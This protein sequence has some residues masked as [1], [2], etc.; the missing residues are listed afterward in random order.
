MSY[1]PTLPHDHTKIIAADLRSQFAGLKTLI[2]A[3]P[4]GQVGPQGPA[5]INGIDG[6]PGPQGPAGADGRAV[7]GVSDDG[8]GRG[9]VQMSDGTTYGP[10]TIASG[11]QGMTGNQGDP[12]PQGVPGN[13]GSDGAPGPQGPQ[14]ND[15]VS[16]SNVYDDGT[17]RAVIQLS[18]GSSFGPFT[19]ASGPQGMTGNDGPQGP[20]GPVGEISSMDL[21]TA[22]GSTSA[23]TNGVDLIAYSPSD[24][25]T[26]ADW[27]AL[28]DKMNELITAL[29]R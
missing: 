16:V 23:N 7:V 17:G 20:Q 24:P 2:D 25:P 12:G 19:I 18:N 29:R 8:M 21:N 4:P 3:V 9:V 22:I 27:Q 5:G 28:A 15:G 6:A 1:D 14:G 13:N 10:F 26:A 11:P